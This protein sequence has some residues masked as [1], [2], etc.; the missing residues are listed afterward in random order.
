MQEDCTN[1]VPKKTP[2]I[3]VGTIDFSG[4]ENM[5]SALNK[6]RILIYFIV[7]MCLSG[8][9]TGQNVYQYADSQAE[10]VIIALKD[11]DVTALSSLF[12]PYIREQYR[13]DEDVQD[14]FSYI[15]GEIISWDAPEGKPGEKSVKAGDT[16]YYIIYGY[17]RNIKTDTGKCYDTTICGFWKNQENPDHI[18]IF[19]IQLK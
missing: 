13:L 18:G 7:C 4:H 10:N 11:K 1:E 15:D 19:D 8:C 14:L 5:Y 12:A 6:K 9:N 16:I 3:T 2:M 17:I